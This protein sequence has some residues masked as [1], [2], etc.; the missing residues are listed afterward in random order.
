[1]TASGADTVCAP[2]ASV[3]SHLDSWLNAIEDAQDA[4]LIAERQL[5]TVVRAANRHG[6]SWDAIGNTLGTTRQSAWQKFHDP[7]PDS[8]KSS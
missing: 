5:R 8:G 2:E 1:M 3:S 6:C 4:V 7:C